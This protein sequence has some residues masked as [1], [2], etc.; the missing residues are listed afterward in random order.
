MIMHK[1]MNAPEG[2]SLQRDINEPI[3]K[4]NAARLYL[5]CFEGTLFSISF[6]RA[7][8]VS[9]LQKLLNIPNY[10]S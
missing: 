1:I 7:F 4:R 3:R 10:G 8:S 2:Q 5:T 6:L 9:F